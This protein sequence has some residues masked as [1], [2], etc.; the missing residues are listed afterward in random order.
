MNQRE[1]LLAFLR[2]HG[3]TTCADLEKLC[4]VRSVTTRMAEL[5]RRGFPIV[6]TTAWHQN[7]SGQP[8]RV[9][10]YALKPHPIQ[11][12]LFAPDTALQ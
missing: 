8:R 4:D 12:D 10:Y 9:T 6:K 11:G 7:R 2:T 1:I 3:P 5:I